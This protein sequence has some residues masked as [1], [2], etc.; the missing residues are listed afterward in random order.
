MRADFAFERHGIIFIVSG[1]S[2]AG[3]STLVAGLLE[4]ISGLTPSVS[5]TTRPPRRSEQ[6]GREYHF[7]D[8]AEFARRRDRHEFAE[9]AEVHGAYYGTIRRPLDDAVAEGRD[10]LLD[11]DVQ[12]ARHLK[13]TYRE[14]AVAV[15]IFPPSW[16]ELERRLRARRTEDDAT[17][18]RRLTRARDEAQALL[19]YDYWLVNR[20]VAETTT[21]LE[22]IVV[23][24]RAKVARVVVEAAP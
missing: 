5:C 24:E 20:D 7:V 6:D 21:R 18:V 4:R 3:K 9:W 12:G 19:E 23:A 15:M 17:V 2:G 10:M 14:A 1:P 11:I 16:D 13:R 22:S 8:A